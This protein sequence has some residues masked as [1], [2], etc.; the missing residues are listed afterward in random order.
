MANERTVIRGIVL[1]SVD[2]READ[3]ILT[4]LTGEMGKLAVV[5]K[6]ARGRRSRVTAATQLLAYSEMT[7]AES[8]GWQILS[9]A[10]TIELFSGV[11]RDLER[12][13][14][15]SYFADLVDAV[16][17][18]DLPAPEILPLLLNA[19]YALGTLHYPPA[20]VKPAFE[21]KLMA[22]SGFEPLL[23]RCAVCGAAEIEE[24]MLDVV[25]GTLHC[26]RC[27]QKG[28]LSMPLGAAGLAALR[29]I[30]YGD[31]KR[32]YAFRLPE[33]AL[34]WVNHAAEAYVAAQL[35]RGFRT[36]DYY[37]QVRTD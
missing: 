25:R 8:R 24:P 19:L 2:T 17:Y 23:D 18:E 15:A 30:I 33:E 32:L 21:V 6:G 5:A 35:E 12:L 22:L 31:P 37:K 29:H 13:S 36:L 11:R 10:S 16:T 3:K 27:P 20:V 34:R 28:G 1:R 26:A 4:V 9:E 7:V 14:L